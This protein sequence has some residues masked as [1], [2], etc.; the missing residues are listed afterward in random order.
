MAGRD[1]GGGRPYSS[2]TCYPTRYPERRSH[3][4][5]EPKINKNGLST[6]RLACHDDW[7]TSFH[8]LDLRPGGR[9]RLITGPAGGTAHAFDAVYWDV[10]P[11][12]RIVFAYDMHLDDTRISV[13][14]ATVE[15]FPSGRGTRLVFTEQGAFLD[16]YDDVAGR[17][18]GTRIG[19]ENLARVLAEMTSVA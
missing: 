17:E 13:S 15:F 9:E 8:E 5:K 2:R 3:P 7:V 12:Q 6:R 4:S 16:G 1:N 14:L 11:D 18:E 19:L 10:V